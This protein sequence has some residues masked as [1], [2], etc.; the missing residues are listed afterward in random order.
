MITD[1]WI[2]YYVRTPP[3]RDQ[4]C[5]ASTLV[6][7]PGQPGQ[8]TGN[9][10]N[11]WILRA[12]IYY[13]MEKYWHSSSATKLPQ[14]HKRFPY[15][16][17]DSSNQSKRSS[18]YIYHIWYIHIW[19]VYSIWYVY[20]YIWYIYGM[21][22]VYIYIYRYDI[23]IYTGYMLCMYTYIYIHWYIYIHTIYIWCVYI[24]GVY[25][26]IYYVYVMNCYEWRMTESGGF[27]CI[28]RSLS[29]ASWRS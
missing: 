1:P 11:F 21:Y 25:I 13:Q 24:Y 16:Y 17:A 5:C 26:Y 29:H 12:W 8:M 2:P 6:P 7:G 9:N 3:F 28:T 14:H 22:D 10:E 27:G 23:Y 15:A 20:M 4:S 18:L 19:Y